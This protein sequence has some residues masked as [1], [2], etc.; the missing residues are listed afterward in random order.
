MILEQGAPVHV[1]LPVQIM[2][3]DSENG[4]LWEGCS[5]GDTVHAD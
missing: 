1:L 2:V 4:N 3:D 5:S